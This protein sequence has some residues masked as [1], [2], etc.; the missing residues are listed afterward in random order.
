MKPTAV[1]YF[2]IISALK[3][4]FILL[5]MSGVLWKRAKEPT[6]RFERN[7]AF[8]SE[9]LFFSPLNQPHDNFVSSDFTL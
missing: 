8:D 9:Q 3:E 4:Q 5:Q 2:V 7:V 1:I 6:I